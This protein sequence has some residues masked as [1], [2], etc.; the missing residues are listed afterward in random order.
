MKG[1][2]L[3]LESC[4]TAVPFIVSWLICAIFLSV[5]AGYLMARADAA[6]K[7]EILDKLW[8]AKQESVQQ[9]EGES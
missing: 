3:A 9:N 7:G 8:P 1:K 2:L 4:L 6:R 5:K